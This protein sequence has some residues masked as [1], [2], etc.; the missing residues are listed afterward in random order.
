MTP[1]AG[2]SSSVQPHTEREDVV[3]IAVYDD[4]DDDDEPEDEDDGDERKMSAE[5]RERQRQGLAM[6]RTKRHPTAVE[7]P[8]EL[9]GTWAN[10]RM[11]TES[12]ACELRESAISGSAGARLLFNY[13]RTLIQNPRV[14][15]NAVL[16]LIARSTIP[17]NT[18]RSRRHDDNDRHR[19]GP[20]SAMPRPVADVNTPMTDAS[21]AAPSAPSS[22][23]WGDSVPDTAQSSLPAIA[24]WGTTPVVPAPT[25]VQAPAP[26]VQTPAPVPTPSASSMRSMSVDD[27][28]HYYQT[29]S[30]AEWPIGMR[31]N[32]DLGDVPRGADVRLTPRQA[33]VHAIQAIMV[34]SPPGSH[35]HANDQAFQHGA[36]RRATTQLFSIPGLFEAIHR[37]AGMSRR[38]MRP[39]PYPLPVNNLSPIQVAYWFAVHGV[40]YGHPILTQ[41]EGF[42]RARRNLQLGRSVSDLSPFPDFPRDLDDALTANSRDGTNEAALDAQFARWLEPPAP[43]IRSSEQASMMDH[44]NSIPLPPSTAGSLTPLSAPP[45]TTDASS[46]H[47]MAF[48]VNGRRRF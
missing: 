27:L 13:Y 43:I 29:V 18:H 19:Q 48:L 20:S 17:G 14:R 3:S 11:D 7:P 38:A 22:M 34:L 28:S 12:D 33:D 44:A 41:L 42:A 37:R 10:A 9:L 31:A 47:H 35:S 23:Q 46:P 26:V 32:P 39:A 40:M 4:D 1:V 25:P 6:S 36:F 16:R 30:P 15:R 24:Q 2:S 5:D 8:A 21:V 45:S